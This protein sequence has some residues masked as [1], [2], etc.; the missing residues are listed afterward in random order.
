MAIDYASLRDET[1][2]KLM[3]EFGFAMTVRSS[4]EPTIDPNTGAVTA[5]AVPVDTTV[6]GLYRFYSQDEIFKAL[7]AG[8]DILANDIQFLIDASGLDAAG[9]DPDTAMQVIAQGNT[10]NVVRNTPT[11]PGGVALLYRLQAR[12]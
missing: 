8:Q 12:K 1:V 7:Q 4:R 9:I 11:Q 2:L 3:K 5:A 6:Y 10:Y